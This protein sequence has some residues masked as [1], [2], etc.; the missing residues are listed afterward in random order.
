M[1]CMRRIYATT[2]VL[3]LIS[4][5]SAAA[6]TGESSNRRG[7]GNDLAKI[8]SMEAARSLD[9]Q[10]RALAA[11]GSSVE[12]SQVDSKQ[13]RLF[14]MMAEAGDYPSG[15]T[16]KIEGKR[17]APVVLWNGSSSEFNIED[18][19]DVTG[20]FEVTAGGYTVCALLGESADEA[21]TMSDPV[22]GDAACSW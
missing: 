9:R 20:V 4:G 14:I 6:D 8:S 19:P 2:L 17:G 15:I 3:L 1:R 18:V 21:A 11:L 10:V 13:S 12:L 22:E 7:P 5:C 16:V